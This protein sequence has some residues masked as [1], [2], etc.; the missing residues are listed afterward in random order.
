MMSTPNTMTRAPRRLAWLLLGFLVVA[1]DARMA[2]SALAQAARPKLHVIM[3]AD[4]NAKGIG[5]SCQIDADN[6][7]ETFTQFIPKSQLEIVTVGQ[8]SL[9][10]EVM[11]DAIRHLAIVPDVDTVMIYY[12]GHG[13]YS[14][15]RREHF[16]T[17]SGDGLSVPV[18]RGEMKAEL[19][20]HKPRLTVII[21]DSCSDLVELRPAP[22]GQP[23][24]IPEKVAPLFAS[25]FFRTKG[26]VDLSAT[27]PGQE[28]MGNKMIGGLFTN[29]LMSVLSNNAEHP[30]AWAAVLRQAG[31]Q[32][33]QIPGADQTA[34]AVEALPEPEGSQGGIGAQRV[35]LGVVGDRTGK[36]A[37]YDGV[38][39][40]SVFRDMPATRV[41]GENGAIVTL[42][43][44]RDVI[45]HVNGS[46]VRTNADLLR[47]IAA[48]GA[49]V[50]LR[51]VNTTNSTAG[52]YEAVLTSDGAKRLRLGAIAVG[53]NA[54]QEVGG[55]LVTKVFAGSPA[56]RI[57]LGEKPFTLVPYRDIIQTMNG[58][59]VRSNAEF[60]QAIKQSGPTMEIQVFDRLKNTTTTYTAELLP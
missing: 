10:R 11:L 28:A 49:T 40:L 29:S 18:F 32:T 8:P 25:L 34:Y 12:S 26:L 16:V 57:K 22:A 48:A 5:P 37:R 38:E 23:H 15:K 20:K 59:D 3:F 4:V 9:G 33:S 7:D 53:G 27:R 14:E 44:G 60:L 35:R 24:V 43:V 46:P 45:T 17:A 6:L 42:V 31:R 13:G 51:V 58:K 52:N 2:P 56:T 41:K 50:L 47:E 36:S 21:T 55:V 1:I 54:G 19:A 39:V 30:L